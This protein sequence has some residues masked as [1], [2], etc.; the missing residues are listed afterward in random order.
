MKHPFPVDRRHRLV[1]L[2]VMTVVLL[3]VLIAV[4]LRVTIAVLLRAMIVHRHE[5]VA[6]RAAV[7]LHPLSQPNHPHRRETTVMCPRLLRLL[8]KAGEAVTLPT[9]GAGE[10]GEGGAGAGAEGG[11]LSRD[12]VTEIHKANTR[13]IQCIDSYMGIGKD[14]APRE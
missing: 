8:R 3:R 12:R 11:D 5:L 2:R 7:R 6:I 13:Y 14:M 1:L 4:L 9:I 10:A